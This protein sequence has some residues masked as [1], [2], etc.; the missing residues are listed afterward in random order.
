VSAEAPA[1]GGPVRQKLQAIWAGFLG[2]PEVAP[3]EDLFNLGVD[4]LLSIRAITAIREAFQTDL[5]LDTLF[6]LRTVA[7]QAAEIERRLGQ[8]TG[9]AAPPIVASGAS[10][11]APLSTSQQRLWIISQLERNH[12]AYNT[13]FF[14]FSQDVDVAALEQTFRTIIERHAILR[15]VYHQVDGEPLQSVRQHFD[16]AI[17][18]LDITDLPPDQRYRRGQELWRQALLTP[19]SLSD[20]LMMRVRLVRY[21]GDTHLLMVTQHHICSD[22]WSTNLLMEEISQLYAAYAQG[23]PNPLPPLPVQYLDYALW[24][25]AWLG[26]GALEA[27]LA[28][29]SGH[30]A[31]IPAVH[32]LPLDHPR[33]AQQSYRG[34]QYTVRLDNGVLGGLQQL[35][36]QHGATLFMTM[37]A[38]FAVLL[39]RYSGNQDIVTGFS[40]ANRLHR[41]LESVIGFFVNTLVMRSD[42]SGDPGFGAFLERTRQ[43][44][45][46]AYANQHVPFEKLVDALRPARSLSY[47]PV[48]QVM[49][50]FLDQSQ[51]QGGRKMLRDIAKHDAVVQEDM[52][53]PF[54]K[55]DLSLYFS[56]NEGTLELTWEYATDLFEA[57]TITRMADNFSTLLAGIVADPARALSALPLVGEADLR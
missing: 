50:I 16:F 38:A 17:E 31:G 46:S 36:Q 27:Q 41:E 43:R 42:L 2:L 10:G 54:S 14:H 4:S 56:V 32:S 24:Q 21:D 9:P 57:A 39:G 25:N 22:N 1:A 3:H 11:P 35:S 55:Y 40:V 5:S 49:L 30:L 51:A 33:P 53:V 20:D 34:R 37:Q 45:L 44:L 52:N 8:D 19:I 18:R 47:E 26:T 12:T 48:V 23:R 29:W 13:G 28:Y 15:T 6:V 7:E